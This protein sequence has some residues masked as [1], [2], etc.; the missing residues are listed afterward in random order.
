MAKLSE[1]GTG[2]AWKFGDSIASNQISGAPRGVS[3]PAVLRE[4]CLKSVRPEF[5]QQVQEG[6]ILVAGTN[7]GNGSSSPGGITALQS[8]GLQAIVA[9]SVSRLMM[10]T[11]IARGLPAF[12]APGVTGIVE[13]GDSVQIDYAAGVVRNPKSGAEVS[14][15]RFPP[16]VERIYT[17]G[18]LSAVIAERLAAEGVLPP[19]AVEAT[20]TV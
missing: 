9:D 12:A 6:D 20:A 5:G 2:R 18:G 13:D 7:F 3:D 14:F 19:P 4:T 15:R 17:L 11:C 8:C 16:T 10:R 1:L